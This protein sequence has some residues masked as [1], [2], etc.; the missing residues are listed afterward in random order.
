METN[1]ETNDRYF[2]GVEELM[3]TIF[4]TFYAVKRAISREQDAPVG[5]GFNKMPEGGIST[6][7]FH[8][9]CA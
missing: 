1:C 4:S 7:R 3:M 8:S 5:R 6:W 2:Q 9:S